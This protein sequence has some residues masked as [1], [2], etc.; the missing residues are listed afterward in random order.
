MLTL[1]STEASDSWSESDSSVSDPDKLSVRS[2]EYCQN[3]AVEHVTLFNLY[4]LSHLL[5]YLETADL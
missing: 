4:R 5:T 2:T 1:S 3:I